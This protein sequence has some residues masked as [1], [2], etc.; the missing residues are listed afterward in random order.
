MGKFKHSFPYQSKEL[1]CKLTKHAKLR[2]EPDSLE[3]LKIISHYVEVVEAHCPRCKAI[4]DLGCSREC[5]CAD[6]GLFVAVVEA[7]DPMTAAPLGLYMFYSESK[8]R[9][10]ERKEEL[11]KK[12][13]EIEAQKK[14]YAKLNE[15]K[16]EL[17][18]QAI[19]FMLMN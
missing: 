11:K 1:N 14:E 3:G 15:V 4:I 18:A 8:D 19:S 12:Q 7:K 17:L 9:M 13:E 6:C 2:W 10:D 16:R 5:V